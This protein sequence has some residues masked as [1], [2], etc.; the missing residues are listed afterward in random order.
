LVSEIPG[1]PVG[2]TVTFWV[3]AW[4]KDIVVLTS[5]EHSYGVT[6]FGYEAYGT[7]L[8]PT[9]E[10]YGAY[11]VSLLLSVLVL[12]HF[13]RTMKRARKENM[14]AISGRTGEKPDG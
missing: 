3:E 12:I 6:T 13:T 14:K 10:V 1:Y 8:F 11:A 5:E 9:N 4:D 7:E 2:T